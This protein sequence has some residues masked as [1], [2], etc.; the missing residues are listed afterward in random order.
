MTH[1]LVRAFLADGIDELIAH[2]TAIEAA[3]GLETDHRSRW[4]GKC[5][6]HSGLS[7]TKRIAARLAA[8]LADPTTVGSYQEL[9]DLR[10][11]FVHGRGGLQS[12]PAA[13][14]AMARSLAR[15]GRCWIAR[16]HWGCSQR[17]A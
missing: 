4:R 2:K 8:A 7:A 13:K 14:R 1:F 15:R 11:A 16:Q 17:L 5:V 10:G 12:I 6:P 3:L 9:F